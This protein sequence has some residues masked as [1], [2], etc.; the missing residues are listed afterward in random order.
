MLNNVHMWKIITIT[1]IILFWTFHVFSLKIILCRL[2]KKRT[3]WKTLILVQSKSSL[4]I[5]KKKNLS[6]VYK[7]W[8]MLK[9]LYQTNI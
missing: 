3:K 2:K 4:H 9:K 6:K 7:Q 5:K 8:K 1:W